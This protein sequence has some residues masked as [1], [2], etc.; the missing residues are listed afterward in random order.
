MRQSSRRTVLVAVVLAH[1]AFGASAMARTAEARAGRAEVGNS[2]QQAMPKPG[3]EAALRHLIDSVAAGRPDYASMTPKAQATT[4]AQ[5]GRLRAALRTLGAFQAMSFAE[6]D[7]LRGDVY[8][9][10]FVNGMATLAIALAPDAKVDGWDI[11]GVATRPAS[12]DH[13]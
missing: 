2:A 7:R 5:L 1:C 9:V 3:S 10:T 11:D 12:T 8:T 4:K 13:H 6:T